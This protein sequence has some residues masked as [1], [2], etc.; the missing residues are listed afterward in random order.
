MKLDN[1]FRHRLDRATLGAGVGLAMLV[2]AWVL[3]P[4]PARGQPA[5]AAIE[6]LRRGDP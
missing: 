4:T 3:C 6:L 5:A 2:A 1:V